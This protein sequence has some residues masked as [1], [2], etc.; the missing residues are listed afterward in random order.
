MKLDNQNKAISFSDPSQTI[1]QCQ[2]RFLSL[3]EMQNL[4]Q[5][6][7]N[8]EDLLSHVTGQLRA[9]ERLQCWSDSAAKQCYQKPD[10]F[11]SSLCFSYNQ[12]HLMSFSSG[13]TE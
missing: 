8:K 12:H 10:F 11:A 9:I 1:I 4:I 7:L 6:G 2:P 5:T 13:V 3:Y